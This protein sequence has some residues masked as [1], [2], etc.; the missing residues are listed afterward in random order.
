MHIEE[1]MSLGMPSRSPQD[2]QRHSAHTVFDTAHTPRYRLRHG[3]RAAA[4]R[5]SWHAHACPRPEAK[6]YTSVCSFPSRLVTCHLLRASRHA[7]EEPH[8]R[9]FDAALNQSLLMCSC[10]APPQQPDISSLASRVTPVSTPPAQPAASPFPP[11]P[12]TRQ[13]ASRPA[14]PRATPPT[15]KVGRLTGAGS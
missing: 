9:A 10:R 15:Q 14:S 4:R 1:H 6:R 2:A 3:T 13:L 5:R 7:P 11:I 12:A 8:G